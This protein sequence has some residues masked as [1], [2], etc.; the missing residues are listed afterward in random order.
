MADLYFYF[1]IANLVVTVFL[2]GYLAISPS[3]TRKAFLFGVKIPETEQTNPQVK[4]IKRIYVIGIIITALMI[5]IADIFQYCKWPHLTAFATF[6]FPWAFFVGH[7]VFYGVCWTKAK[8]LKSE[9]NWS[10][11]N[12]VFAESRSSFT[13]GKLSMIPWLYYIFSLV[14]IAITAI[15]SIIIYPSLPDQIVMVFDYRM[16]P[17]VWAAKTPFSVMFYSL[18]GAIKL[19][20]LFGVSIFFVVRAK[21]QISTQDPALS[22]A[23]HRLYRRYVSHGFGIMTVGFIIISTLVCFKGLFPDFPLTAALYRIAMIVSCLPLL[24]ILFVSGQGGC[25]LKPKT[26][27]EDSL[28]AG[29]ENNETKEIFPGR[30]DDKYWKLGAFYYNPDD[31]V[32]MIEDRFGVGIDLNYSH[33]AAKVVTVLAVVTLVALYAW[34]TPRVL[35]PDFDLSKLLIWWDSFFRK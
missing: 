23:Q 19:A 14:L 30:G 5:L 7:S 18:V 12:V 6:Y 9:N 31:P 29:Y 25:K 35:S 13:R 4:E 33:P 11:S 26:S 16:E 34:L 3:L 2:G 20:I 17:N 27:K 24:V 28:A 1:F 10:V 21:L 22:F 8:A 32:L 15:V